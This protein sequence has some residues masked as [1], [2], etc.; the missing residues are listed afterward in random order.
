M[1]LYK[2]PRSPYWYVRIG[3]KTRCST[4]TAN[5]AEAEEFERTLQERL[6]RLERLGDRGAVPWREVAERWLKESAKPKRRDREL[7]EWLAPK[8]GQYSVADVADPDIVLK[9]RELGLQEGWSHSTVDRLM[10][11]VRAVLKRAQAW[12]CI[13]AVPHIP[14]YGQPQ[15]EPRWLTAAEFQSLCRE[16]PPHLALAARF[17]VLTGLRMRAMLRLTWDRIDL[18]ARR[19][20]VPA[21]HMKAA[22][23][24][25]L[26]LSPAA[27]E[28]LLELRALNPSG[29]W[30]F[31]WNGHP[32]DDCN[33]RAFQ[34][35]VKRAGIGPLRWH[36]LRHTFASWAVQN[37]VRL[38]ELMQLGG[39]SDY[40][41]A[42]RYGHLAPS[43]VASA[44]ERV[45]N[46]LH[47]PQTA[48][49]GSGREK[50]NEISEE[51]G[52]AEGDRTLDLRIAKAAGRR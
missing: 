33:T 28:V 45:A 18:E 47:T 2:H 49:I 39:W 8:I 23:T 14:M 43:Q 4:G 1:P 29:P 44:A 25:A 36:D 19:A 17:A 21:S 32:I 22:K 40:R 48:E 11:T 50:A 27:V 10:A 30:V 41:M 6:W 38:E 13:D 7:L 12:R 51:D 52:G 26:S 46:M 37:G 20:W 24:L 16:L 5:R 15:A 35:A 3:R 9:I 42:L 31:Q 34:A